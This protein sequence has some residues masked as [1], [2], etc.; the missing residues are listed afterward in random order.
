[1]D[2]NPTLLRTSNLPDFVGYHN[3]RTVS[4]FSYRLFLLVRSIRAT[5]RTHKILQ[6]EKRVSQ[7]GANIQG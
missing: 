2:N 7:N 5:Y 4:S 3:I 6:L 1:M